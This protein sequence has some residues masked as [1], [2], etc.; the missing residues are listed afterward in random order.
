MKHNRCNSFH[1]APGRKP[2]PPVCA[3]IHMVPEKSVEL[4]R[5]EYEKL[6]AY[7]TKVEIITAFVMRTGTSYLEKDVLRDVLGLTR[8][9]TTKEGDDE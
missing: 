5:R 6:I 7:K 2:L 8:H 9:A 4:P 1:N 3:E